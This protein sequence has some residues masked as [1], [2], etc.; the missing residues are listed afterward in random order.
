MHL[1]VEFACKKSINIRAVWTTGNEP[2]DSFTSRPNRQLGKVNVGFNN[3]FKSLPGDDHI[4][5]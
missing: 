1:L 5:I 4:G 3:V 2:T